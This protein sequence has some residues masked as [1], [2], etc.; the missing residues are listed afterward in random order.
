MKKI[1][2]LPLALCKPNP[3]VG[4]LD[5]NLA[6]IFR[7]VCDQSSTILG[8]PDADGIFVGMSMIEATIE[9]SQKLAV[10]QHKRLGSTSLINDG[11]STVGR[12]AGCVKRIGPID[13]GRLGLSVQEESRS[14]RY[15]VDQSV[16]LPHQRSDMIGGNF[17][18]GDL[19]SIALSLLQLCR[20]VLNHRHWELSADSGRDQNEPLAVLRHRVLSRSD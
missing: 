19:H 8:T 5:I 3:G 10:P 6:I 7:A 14:A 20:P 4:I 17:G 16:A 15:P 11:V 2:R 12:R 1:R 18:T 13:S 9:L